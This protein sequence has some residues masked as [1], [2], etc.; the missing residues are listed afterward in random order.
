[1][2]VNDSLAIIEA[3]LFAHGEPITPDRLSDASGI[4][5]QTAVKLVEQLER[6]YNVSDSGLCVLTLNGGFQLATRAEFSSHVKKALATKR[7]APLTPAAMETLAIIA[8]NQ[9]V[10]KAFV[11]QVRGTDSNYVVNSLAERGLIIDIG[12]LDLPGRPIAYKT[13]D[14]FLRCFGL[15]GMSEL[16][17]LPEQEEQLSFDTIDE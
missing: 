12:R 1:M 14:T 8:Y 13:T 15:S 3:I 5:V 2:N 7:Q 17:P 9:P 11:E 4:D 6:K 10:T 16:P